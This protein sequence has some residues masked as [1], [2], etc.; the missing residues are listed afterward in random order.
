MSGRRGNRPVAEQYPAATALARKLTG[1][2]RD[3]AARLEAEGFVNAAG[4]RFSLAGIRT[5][6]GASAKGAA[7][8]EDGE[9]SDADR[10]RACDLHL[11]DLRRHE[12]WPDTLDDPD[13]DRY[14][15]FTGSPAAMFSGCGSPAA[16]VAA[17]LGA[18]DD[19]EAA[20]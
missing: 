8:D 10:R 19:I 17:A 20:C 4:R 5:M 16:M 11:A 6:R 3:I 9:M 18:D 2:L 12:L 15:R 7:T 13:R 14:P 1:S